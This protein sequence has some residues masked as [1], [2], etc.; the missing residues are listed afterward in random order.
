MSIKEEVDKII[1]DQ[2]EYYSQYEPLKSPVEIT[3]QNG[4]I[5]VSAKSHW[6]KTYL[7]EKMILNFKAKGWN[8]Q[9]L[10]Y[11][12]ESEADYWNKLEQAGCEIT[13]AEI[14]DYKTLMDFFFSVKA[15]SVIYIDD[16]DLYLN[17]QADNLKDAIN[18]IKDFFSASR[19]ANIITIYSVK[20]IK[21]PP[22][23]SFIEMAELLFLGKFNRFSNAWNSF[24]INDLEYKMENLPNHAFIMKSDEGVHLIKAEE[25]GII[26]LIKYNNEIEK[27][28]KSRKEKENIE[29][30]KKKQKEIEDRKNEEENKIKDIEKEDKERKEEIE[31]AKQETEEEM[32]KLKEKE[33]ELKKIAKQNE[34][35]EINKNRK[36][37]TFYKLQIYM[38]F[39]LGICL[40]FISVYSWLIIVPT[41]VLFY[42]KDKSDK[43]KLINY[44]NE[45]IDLGEV[46]PINGRLGKNTGNYELNYTS[47]NSK[48]YKIYKKETDK[49]VSIQPNPKYI[50]KIKYKTKITKSTIKSSVAI[51]FYLFAI[52]IAL[53]FIA[54]TQSL[55][56]I[57]VFLTFELSLSVISY[58]V[59]LLYL[60]DLMIADFKLKFVMYSL[61]SI[62]L[63][64]IAV[65]YLPFL[66][67][68]LAI[69]IL[70]TL[71]IKIK[72][73]E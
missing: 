14:T 22:W 23:T 3:S 45:L 54:S 60:I 31:R 47:I 67:F 61:F 63:V 17:D 15:N 34:E 72:S 32:K 55:Y 62:L 73:I 28:I 53:F 5:L 12:K 19:K 9:I 18:I 8:V 42:L 7:I 27:E 6:G 48:S 37:I 39:I 4:R 11:T 33:K 65:S 36:Y 66:A 25:D 57:P 2:E 69:G 50:G 13:Y 58:A 40:S 46:Y 51:G 30:K 49:L 10:S 21:G 41:I 35:K 20:Q 52:F 1:L 29:E 16:L 68:P 38:L 43:I 70:M 64:F 56:S 24:G 59:I 44:Q 26:D 71:K